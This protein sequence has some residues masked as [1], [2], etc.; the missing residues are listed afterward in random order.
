MAETPAKTLLLVE[1]EVIVALNQRAIL[2]R[3]GYSVVTVHSG[4][5]AIDALGDD[6]TIDLIL[7]DIDLGE[8]MSGAEAAAAILRVHNLPIV[9]VTSH[10]ERE[11]VDRVQGIPRYGYVL[12]PVGEPVLMEAITI[13]FELFS[14]RT[15]AEARR[16]CRETALDICRLRALFESSDD[17]M[18]LRDAEGRFLEVNSAAERFFARPAEEILGRRMGELLE[19]GAASHTEQID[20]RVLAGESVT[21]EERAVVDGEMRVFHV[22]AHPVFGHDKSVVE[23]C[24][25]A[26][27]VT[28][29]RNQQLEYSHILKTAL[30]GFLVFDESARILQANHAAACMLGYREE[31]LLSLSIPHIDVDEDEERVREHMAEVREVGAQ[32]FEARHRRKD[33][34]IVNVE[35]SI[36]YLSG[37][38][39]R[40]IA[41]VRDIGEHQVALQLLRHLGKS[42]DTHE[43][44]TDV[45]RIMKDWAGCDAVGVRLKDG[46]DYPYFETRGFPPEFVKTERY[47]CET[48]RDGRIVRDASG[49]PILECICG[50]VIRGESDPAKPFFTEAG[51]FFTKSTTELLSCSTAEERQGRT[52][53]RCNREGF[54]SVAL[55]PIRHGSEVLGLLQFNDRRTGRFDE[56]AVE[57]FEWFATNLGLGLKQRRD[58]EALRRN[59]EDL[60][61]LMENADGQVWSI[62]T[63]YRLIIANSRFHESIRRGLGTTDEPGDDVLALPRLADVANDWRAYYD[64]AL[65]GEVFSVEIACPFPG[66]GAVPIECRFNPIRRV[67]GGVHGVACFA[68]DISDKKRAENELRESEANLLGLIESSEDIIVLRNRAGE[69]VLYNTAFVAI[70]RRLFGIDGYKGINTVRLLDEADQDRWR[71][72]MDRV[73]A[74]QS[75]RERFSHRFDDGEVR[76]YD[77][78]FNPILRDAEVTGFA[79]FTRD[80]TEMHEIEQRLTDLL[81]EKEYLMAELNHRV[82]NNLAMVS[83]LINLKSSALGDGVDLSDV[84]NQLEAIRAAHEKLSLTHGTLEIRVKGYI[85]DILETVFSSMAKS[86]VRTEIRVDDVELPAKTAMTLGLIIN[87]AATNAVQHAFE[88]GTS[89]EFAVE[90]TGDAAAR[91]YRLSLANSGKPVPACIDFENPDSLGL[92]LIAALSKQLGGTAALERGER[93]VLTV[94]FPAP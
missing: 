32:R 4:P 28:E 13:A 74:G 92:R 42:N 52:R 85:T 62:D 68:R 31:E 39:G 56:S 47:L 79:E 34:G 58:A 51:S 2:E 57:L 54:E 73:L 11:M 20:L 5:A 25:V 59:R 76:W 71:R 82:K 27:D 1:D 77:R 86:E 49:N 64:R 88:P 90:L 48:D 29:Q 87:E 43:L 38:P 7:M 15:E 55:V 23:I 22:K 83:S 81:K 16:S 26:R 18:Y 80:I 75:V 66:P 84:R 91:G 72:S 37:P 67:D 78:M 30:D 19:I 33:G 46:D 53:N 9:F 69:A 36:S 17:V 8:G 3:N 45:T 41:F 70:C 14:A 21:Y 50:R 6:G 65:A 94:R 10:A 60:S 24:A 12:K 44:L 40:F 89:G 63:Q 35:V 61:A 93:T